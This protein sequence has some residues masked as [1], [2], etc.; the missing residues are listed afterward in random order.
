MELAVDLKVR[1]LFKR[2]DKRRQTIA[3][4]FLCGHFVCF[5]RLSD[6]SSDIIIKQDF[7]FRF[8]SRLFTWH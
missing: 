8:V 7:F 5:F 3:S 4:F 2:D 6:L 1:L